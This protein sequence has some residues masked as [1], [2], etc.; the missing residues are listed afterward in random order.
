MDHS[1]SFLRSCLFVPADEEHRAQK[2]LA[3]AADVV[4]LDLEDAVAT[5]RKAQARHAAVQ[6]LAAHPAA[7]V[8]IR[9]NGVHTTGCL[10]DLTAVMAG[11]PAG[12]MLPKAESPSEVAAVAWVMGQLEAQHG[13]DAESIDLVPLVET[14]RGLADIEGVC[15][16]A[17]RV[18]RVAFG[19]ADY[20]ADLGIEWTR[21]E[22]ELVLARQQLVVQSRAAGIEPPID[23]A[24]LEIDDAERVFAAAARSRAGGFQGRLL[25][26]PAQIEPCHRG[27]AP[28]AAELDRAR[29]VLEAFDAAE[30]AGVAAIEVDG[31]L[32]DYA[33]AARARR[34]VAMSR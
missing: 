22:D 26:H 8:W 3:S 24:D 2:A 6:L 16:A 31:R 11:P 12:V 23:A 5:A 32:V 14:A 30:R 18:R 19:A 21:G 20:T 15:R 34:I 7:R 4:V 29:R 33:I 27:F 17:P 9:V 28:S 10:A 1:P 13:W 25:I